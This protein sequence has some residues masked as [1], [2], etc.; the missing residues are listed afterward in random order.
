MSLDS[1]DILTEEQDLSM[2]EGFE[3]ILRGEY[4]TAAEYMAKRRLQRTV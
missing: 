2:K 4:I 1:E 3:Q